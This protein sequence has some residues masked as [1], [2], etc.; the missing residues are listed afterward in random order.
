MS[1]N[2][3]LVKSINYH[4]EQKNDEIILHTKIKLYD[5]KVINGI[6][7]LS[8][9]AYINL[10]RLYVDLSDSKILYNCGIGSWMMYIALNYYIENFKKNKSEVL[11]KSVLESNG[12]YEKIGF[13]LIRDASKS[14]F[15][16]EMTVRTDDLMSNLDKIIESRR[17]QMH[18]TQQVEPEEPVL[19]TLDDE[20]NRCRSFTTKKECE[21][22]N[23][24]FNSACVPSYSSV[25][26]FG[27]KK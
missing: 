3:E 21:L 1:K 9:G 11:V 12:Y 18:I 22:N 15:Y 19:F 20:I 27:K 4:F 8:T 5:G 14:S 25:V 13:Q 7:K 23:C 2:R 6:C 17:P 26:K 16:N 24:N 10:D